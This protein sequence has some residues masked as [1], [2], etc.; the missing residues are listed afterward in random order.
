VVERFNSPSDLNPK[1]TTS[2][3]F[4]RDQK[5]VL[6]ASFMLVLISTPSLIDTNCP[7]AKII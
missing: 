4:L 2:T 5:A 7:L 6:R 3:M 1:A